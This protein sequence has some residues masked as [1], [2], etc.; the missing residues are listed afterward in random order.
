MMNQVWVLTRDLMNTGFALALI[1][2]AVC[3]ARGAEEH[4]TTS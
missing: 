4:T 1:A 3:S 2:A